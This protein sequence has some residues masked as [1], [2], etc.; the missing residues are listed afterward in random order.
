MIG[1]AF[2][3]QFAAGQ[4]IDLDVAD[5]N[6]AGNLNPLGGRV[7]EGTGLDMC[8]LQPTREERDEALRDLACRC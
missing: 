7:S 6:A 8:A 2:V 3:R 4:H 5:A 1:Q